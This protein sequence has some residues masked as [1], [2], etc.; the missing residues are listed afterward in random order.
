M[1]AESVV[2]MEFGAT[3]EDLALTMHAHPTLAETFHDAVLLV[4]NR[5][6]HS[7]NKVKK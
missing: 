6:I 4:D 2:A 3:T 5:A 7:V 1:I